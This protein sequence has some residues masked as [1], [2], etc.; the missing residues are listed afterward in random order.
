MTMTSRQ[1]RLGACLGMVLGLAA[2]AWTAESPPAEARF[3]DAIAR[4]YVHG[5]TPEIAAAEVGPEGVPFLRQRLHDPEVHFRTNVIAFLGQ[6]GGPGTTA[7]LLAFL[8]APPASVDQPEEH[9]ALLLIPLVLGQRMARGDDEAKALLLRLGEDR[10]DGPLAA[11][12]R[13]SRRPEKLHRELLGS[14]RNALQ[15]AATTTAELR[16]E[17]A[18]E[19]AR[20]PYPSRAVDGGPDSIPR[21]PGGSGKVFDPHARRD[22]LGWTWTNHVDATPVPD[23][24]VD[25]F[26][27]LASTRSER[28][29]F[30]EDVACC[31][32]FHR[33]GG[34]AA[35]GAPGDGLDV[36]DDDPEL[37]AV[38]GE[39]SA[40]VKVVR[41]INWC[42]GPA[43]FWGC[44]PVPG[45]TMVV[46]DGLD[47][48]PYHEA[49]LWV[50]EYGHNCGLGHNGDGRYFM[51][52]GIDGD[53]RALTPP[54]CAALHD[55]PLATSADRTDAGACVDSDGD[56]VGDDSDNCPL[57]PNPGQENVDGDASGDAC[58]PCP[59]APLDDCAFLL[60]N[61][62]ITSPSAAAV[63]A[64]LTPGDPALDR[65]RDLHTSDV[66]RFPS[67][68][69]PG[70]ALGVPVG[71][72]GVLIFYALANSAGPLVAVRAG[73][74]V[75]LSGW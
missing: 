32:S 26:A 74:D 60:R 14:T 43:S 73:D 8:E 36:I 49:A 66:T 53:E 37:W 67:L 42:G 22:D 3:R 41:A 70:D 11:A 20:P 57:V 35:F 40:R 17:D 15:R 69:L 21:G 64:V 75:I 71:D 30:A 72:P 19:P 7:D 10:P 23:T 34:A 44:A 56:E 52:G 45:N 5:I 46:I 9:R 1:P 28:S 12:A 16:G 39:S 48:Y 4:M 51:V 62:T 25:L 27:S 59:L 38:L 68:L 13:R 31:V 24:R 58:D 47:G 54:E 61:A 2:A 33:V 65:A 55:P 50:H 6:L 18:Q 29:D 63:A